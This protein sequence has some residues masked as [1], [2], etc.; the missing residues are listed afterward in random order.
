MTHPSMWLISLV[1]PIFAVAPAAGADTASTL[2]YWQGV[3]AT[4]LHVAPDATPDAVERAC[5]H[6]LRH[7]RKLP[8]TNV[9]RVPD[10][11]ST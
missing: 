4:R 8:V 10:R 1:Y 6:A 11:A 9:D 3:Q 7:L 5:R 2:R